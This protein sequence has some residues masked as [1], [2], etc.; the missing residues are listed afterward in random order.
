MDK[1]YALKL[2][3]AALDPNRTDP[4]GVEAVEL[5]PATTS[6]FAF[7]SHLRVLINE[8]PR[9]IEVNLGLLDATDVTAAGEREVV[10]DLGPEVET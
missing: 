5:V 2:I 8:G 9:W 10:T 1:T 7:E 3:E 4:Y 6:I